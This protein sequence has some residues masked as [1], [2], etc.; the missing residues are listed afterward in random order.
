M[1]LV[2]LVLT[3]YNSK[4][5]FIKTYDSIQKQNYP[6]IE[7]VVVDGASTDGT[8]EE[9]EKRALENPK[10]IW[11]SEKDTGIYNA[12]NKGLHM[13]NGQII[14][15]F[16]D[17]F[18]MDNAVEQYV[19]IIEKSGLEGAHSDLVYKGM[20]G[21]IIRTWKMGEGTIQ[22]GWLPGHPTLYLKRAVY[23]KYGAYN[24][25]Y[26]CAGDYE[27]MVRILKDKQVQL[28][29]IPQTLISMFYG[30][31]SNNGIKA[32]WISFWEGVQ[33][34]KENKVKGALWITLLR[35]FRVLMQF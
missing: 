24:E 26:R 25:K 20:N 15:F 14:A 6:N 18:L 11:I 28:A 23:D 16:N 2:S 5:N 29:Y 19:T 27:F 8:K 30:G 34:L 35:T 33:A 3:T 22:K 1:V 9:I 32:Y 10:L 31:T 17:E 4:E 13:A 21:E 7:I 12:M